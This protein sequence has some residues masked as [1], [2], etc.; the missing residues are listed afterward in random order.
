MTKE[1]DK[2]KDS[3]DKAERRQQN[4]ERVV[5]LQKQ[6]TNFLCSFIVKVSVRQLRKWYSGRG[7]VPAFL[8]CLRY[9]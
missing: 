6:G 5:D 7:T 8:A 1:V 3:L 2:I 4:L 9:P